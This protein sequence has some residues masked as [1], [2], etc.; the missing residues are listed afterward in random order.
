MYNVEK[1]LKRCIH[2]IE[3]QD[4]DRDEYEIICINDGSPDNSRQIILSEKQK[5][6]NLK[7]I[8]Q[9]NK[10]VSIARNNGLDVA[11]GKY[12]LFVD[13]DDYIAQNSLRENL[14]RIEKY[15]AQISFLGFSFIDSQGSIKKQVLNQELI[16]ETYLGIKAYCLARGDGQTDPDRIWAVLINRD[17]LN[18]NNLRFLPNVPFLEDGELLARMLCLAERCIFGGNPFYYRTTRVG[19]ATNSNLFSSQKATDGFLKSAQN[20]YNFKSNSELIQ[21]QRDFL[22]MPICKFVILVIDSSTVPLRMKRLLRMKR[23]LALSGLASIELDSVESEFYKLGYLYNR[24][25]FILV[26][27]L[28]LKRFFRSIITRV[29]MG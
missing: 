25:L 12:V 8:D 1:Y 9:K 28:L 11:K 26:I 23:A 15:N 6:S 21:I 4:I 2:S 14:D 22:N 19:S 20:L 27:F 29:K 24:S 3:K 18:E 7:L 10:G 5:Y 16:D 17:F 13:P